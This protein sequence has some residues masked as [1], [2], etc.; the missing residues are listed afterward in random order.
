[1][2]INFRIIEQFRFIVLSEGVSGVIFCHNLC[3]LVIRNDPYPVEISSENSTFVDLLGLFGRMSKVSESLLHE[4][5]PTSG[6]TVEEEI[7]NSITHIV[8]VVFSLVAT[9][10]MVVYASLARDVWFI[11]AC[12]VYGATLL[13]LHT[14]SSLY[15]SARDLRWK[16]RF[17]VLDHSCIY[18]LI[19]GTYTPFVLGPLRGPLGWSFFGVV[20]GLAILGVFKEALVPKRGG[21]W[22][23]LIYLSM[24]WLCLGFLKP[25]Y[26]TLSFTGFTMLLTGGFVYSL[27]VVFYLWRRMKYNHAIWH[28]FVLGG[29]VCQWIA[30]MTLLV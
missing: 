29:A 13:A 16:R 7:A 30:V 14:A 12:G 4:V 28:L 10:L 20:W 5:H 19:A 11:V 3:S 15:H 25:L 24:G 22:G 18:L 8:G 21:W 26:E 27:G 9:T 1:M 6:F 17:L 2:G 23:S